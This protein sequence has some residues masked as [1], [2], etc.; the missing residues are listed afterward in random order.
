MAAATTSVLSLYGSPAFADSTAGGTSSGSP[1]VLSGNT[2]QAPVDV[3]VNVC[4]NT[5]NVVALLNPAFG[6]S[7][8][9]PAGS[10]QRIPSGSDTSS[11]A[12]PTS[13][14]R[15]GPTPTAHLPAPRPSVPAPRPSVPAEQP[16]VHAGQ[17]S[18]PAGQPSVPAEQPP[19][20]AGQPSVPAEQPSV[21]AEQ[22]RSDAPTS[23]VRQQAPD[24]QMGTMKA[25]GPT[26]A[27]LASTGSGSTLA[28]S[29]ASCT[30][31][32]AGMMLYRRARA[33][34]RR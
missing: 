23:V 29:G 3:P 25:V 27:T 4:G 26:R 6:N 5:V 8:D 34:H 10:V 15:G 14:E 13:P 28:A 31:I 24:S 19:V 17:P 30:L 11:V 2:V 18:V 1:G 7:C 33:A 20:H 16:P 9:S 12:T 21:P 22:Q 32:A